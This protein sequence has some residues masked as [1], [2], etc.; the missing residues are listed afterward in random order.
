[1]PPDD[2]EEVTKDV[3]RARWF[4]GKV[5]EAEMF[6][7]EDLAELDLARVTMTAMADMAHVQGALLNGDDKA[8]LAFLIKA[9][10]AIRYAVVDRAEFREAIRQKKEER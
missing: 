3:E 10:G 1:M 4:D 6:C 5:L 2:T 9:A 7:F 8:A